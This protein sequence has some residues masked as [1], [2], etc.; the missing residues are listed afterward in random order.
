VPK[1][2]FLKRIA[3]DVTP[4][5]D[6]RLGKFPFLCPCCGYEFNPVRARFLSHIK[7]M[8]NGC[9]NWNGS[10]DGHKGY[11]KMRLN[12]KMQ[13]AHRVSYYLHKGPIP[14]GMDVLHKCIG[15]YKCVNP[16]HLYL[17]TDA[18]NVRDIILQRR[19]PS[20]KGSKNNFAVLSDRDIL[21]IRASDKRNVDLA[22]EY[23]VTKQTIGRIKLFQT[24]KEVSVDTAAMVR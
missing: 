14:Q 19:R 5:T 24:W 16:E 9:W 3:Y 20:R 10:N 17:G 15:N 11:G 12:G 8:P 21:N 23:N 18:D 1:D 13:R 22:K 6:L 7:I 4:H 2:Y